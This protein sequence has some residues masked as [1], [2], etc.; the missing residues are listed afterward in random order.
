M[1]ATSGRKIEGGVFRSVAAFL[2]HSNLF[3]S[4]AATGVA[5]STTLLAGHSP[6]FLPLFIVFAAT[7]FVYSLNRLTDIE[8]DVRNVP[9]RAA[10]IGRY[11]R[12]FF[13]AGV[14]LYLLAVGGAFV[15]GL[16]GAPFLVLP[17]VVAALYS[18]F[19]VKQLLLVKNL[20]VGLSWGIIPLGVGFYYGAVFV[21]GI[22][23]PFGF[24]SV[25]LTVAAAV[26]DIKDIEGDRAG[27]IRTVPIVFGPK[28]TRVGALAV[29]VAA[30]VGLVGLVAV[31]VVPRRF[32]VLLGFLA[33]VAAYI[34]FATEDRGPLFYGFVID[35]E[36][37]FLTLL[38]LA[39]EALGAGT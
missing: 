35:G 8:E 39:T 4:V 34:P 12:L 30:G 11:G 16:P 17:V 36:H 38:V 7:L 33:Y 31:G 2:V 27:G 29:T 19:R 37:V 20:I 28:A 25:M 9:S 22:L 6:E 1:E 26:F 5:L 21:P 15:L 14:S 10:F 23:V 24:F 3:I 18:L 13:L 32:L